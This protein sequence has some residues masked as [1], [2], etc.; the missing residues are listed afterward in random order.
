MNVSESGKQSHGYEN[1]IQTWELDCSK[2]L[3]G[4]LIVT[5]AG[6]IKGWQEGDKRAIKGGQE[7]NKSVQKG[8]KRV[9]QGW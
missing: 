6:P 1:T 9:T 8:D 5:I 7:G 4:Y 3:S 2:R